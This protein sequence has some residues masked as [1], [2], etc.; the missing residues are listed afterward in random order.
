V[1]QLSRQQHIVVDTE[2][3]ST[4]PRWAEIVGYS[5]AW[6]PG[7]GYY[8]PVRAPIGERK[9]DPQ[10]VLDML[11]PVLEDPAIGKIGQNIKYDLIVL[12][13]AGIAMAGV[14]FDTM[15]ADYLLDPGERNHSLDD[16]SRRYLNH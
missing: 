1:Q 4:D 3:T 14:A 12:R 16:L 9:L 8:V 7:S 6:E 13:N 15:V 2:S 11:R 10:L 5:F